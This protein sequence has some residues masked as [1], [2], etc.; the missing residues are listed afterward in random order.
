LMSAMTTRAPRLPKYRAYSCPIPRAAPVITM[1][2]S[3]TFMAISLHRL[4]AEVVG[5][6]RDLLALLLGR[7][8]ELGRTANVEDLSGGAEAV[9]NQRI[10]SNDRPD[11]CGDA[12]GKFVRHAGR[13]EE[14]DQAIECELWITGLLDRENIG[15]GGGAD[16]VRD[17][18]QLDFSGL[19]L[20]PHDRQRCHVH[21]NASL[22]EI[23]G[24]LDRVAIGDFGH[25]QVL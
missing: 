4:D 1:T 17:R 19:K 2:F 14:A 18:Q 12:L 8:R 11:V 13:A 16:A 24:G 9:A 23:V 21:L 15:R 5:N 22:G 7:L 6:R 25:R 10:G 20:W 3:S